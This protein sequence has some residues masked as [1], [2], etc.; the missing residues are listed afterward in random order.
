MDTTKDEASEPK[1]QQQAESGEPEK[2]FEIKKVSYAPVFDVSL[3]L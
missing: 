2:R 1:E 3:A